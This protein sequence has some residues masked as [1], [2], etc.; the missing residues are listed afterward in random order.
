MVRKIWTAALAML[1]AVMGAMGAAAETAPAEPYPG[2]N[3]GATLIDAL[4]L[5]Q[6]ENFAAVFNETA[7]D[8][9][10][11]IMTV[12]RTSIGDYTADAVMLEFEN[13]AL[14]NVYYCIKEECSSFAFESLDAWFRRQ[15]GDPVCYDPAKINAPSFETVLGE[16]YEMAD[17][18]PAAY[19]WGYIK[20]K[21]G[22]TF[23]SEIT[24]HRVWSIDD[25]TQLVLSYYKAG[26]FL[27]DDY[28]GVTYV[29]IP[30]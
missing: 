24:D 15:Y 19:S 8:G 3:W 5:P 26:V 12:G 29:N 13:D 9:S 18:Y 28:I 20:G 6:E 10:R 11:D 25:E 27:L 1:L 2:L 14:M 17:G 16:A 7:E 4:V 22:M 21:L 30:G 23:R